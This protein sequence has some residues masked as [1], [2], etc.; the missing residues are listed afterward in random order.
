MLSFG[1]FVVHD[2]E[3][4]SE[5]DVAELSGG[6]DVVDEL[7]EVLQSQIISWGNHAAFIQS[8]VELN[9]DLATSLIINYLK[10]ADVTYAVRVLV[11][12][13]S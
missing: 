8:A 10:F 13:Y 11:C 7:F 6:E 1:L 4:G 5:D 9:N 2:A 3:G 12:C